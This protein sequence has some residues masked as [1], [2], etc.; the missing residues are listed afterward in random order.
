MATDPPEDPIAA[1]RA[2]VAALAEELDRAKAEFAGLLERVEAAAR[3]EREGLTGEARAPMRKPRPLQSGNSGGTVVA[4]M[5][6]DHRLAISK[7][8]AS[9][10]DKKFAKAM[11]DK[12]YSITSLAEACGV[13]KSTMSR[14]RSGLREAPEAIRSSVHDLIGW[15]ANSW[16]KLGS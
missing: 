8:R 5:E 12:G 1:A 4:S 3:E 16:P 14:Y 13:D 10:G 9:R 7:G 11:A 2:R 15:P 6:T